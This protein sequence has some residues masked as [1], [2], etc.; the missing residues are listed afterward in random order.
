MQRTAAEI[1]DINVT[2][3]S[4]DNSYT[5][6][7]DLPRVSEEHAQRGSQIT[8]QDALDMQRS[9]KKQEFLRNLSLWS[10]GRFVAIHMKT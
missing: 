5:S 8:G 6:Y 7:V 1:E 3:L 9:G 10:S 4:E 2:S